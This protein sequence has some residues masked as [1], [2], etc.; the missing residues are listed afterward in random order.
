MYRCPKAITVQP[1]HK[2]GM[3]EIVWPGS[4][5]RKLFFIFLSFWQNYGRGP[6]SDEMLP[7]DKLNFLNLDLAI[8]LFSSNFEGK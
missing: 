5:T 8:A 4:G 7:R 2:N 1:L 6:H 3:K